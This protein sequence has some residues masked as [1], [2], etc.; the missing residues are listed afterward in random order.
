[1]TCASRGQLAE[2]LGVYTL[3]QGGIQLERAHQPQPFDQIQDSLGAG[4]ADRSSQPSQGALFGFHAGDQQ[5][6]Q[7]HALQGTEGLRQSGEGLF[8]CPPTD[9]T[10]DQFNQGQRR[11]HQ[12]SSS[13]LLD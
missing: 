10:N 8:L 6:L 9:L 7:L 11:E 5:V 4:R 1:M 12:L 13:H 2:A 3:H